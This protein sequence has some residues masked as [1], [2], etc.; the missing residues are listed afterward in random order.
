MIIYKEEPKQDIINYKYY[1]GCESGPCWDT[2]SCLEGGGNTYFGDEDQ[3]Y[4]QT[5]SGQLNGIFNC[6]TYINWVHR[7]YDYESGGLLLNC[8]LFLKSNLSIF[9]YCVEF[10][11]NQNTYH[12]HCIYLQDNQGCHYDLLNSNVED[13]DCLTRTSYFIYDN[14]NCCIDICEYICDNTTN[15]YNTSLIGWDIK[16]IK[17]RIWTKGNCGA[18]ASYQYGNFYFYSNISNNSKD[19]YLYLKNKNI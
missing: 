18:G 7:G 10:S 3:F 5:G 16:S 9:R 8:P 12:R 13:I 1:E 6:G 2:C 17:F 11:S 14:I 4:F 15:S 19:E